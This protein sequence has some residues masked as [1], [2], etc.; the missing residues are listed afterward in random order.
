MVSGRDRTRRTVL[1]LFGITAGAG[2]LGTGY[3]AAGGNTDVNGS[4]TADNATQIGKKKDTQENKP[5]GRKAHDTGWPQFQYD[6]ANLG[7]NPGAT[8]PKSN[9]GTQWEFSGDFDDSRFGVAVVDQTV[10]VT[11]SKAV[12]ALSAESGTERWRYHNPNANRQDYASQS[13]TPTPA[14]VDG[15]LYTAF[16]EQVQSNCERTSSG[17]LALN[18]ETGKP[19]W[20]FKSDVVEEFGVPVVADEMVFV[21]SSSQ[22]GGKLY[23]LDAISGE[24]VWETPA[25]SGGITGLSPPSVAVVD[26]IVYNPDTR[27]DC[28][29]RLTTFEAQTGKELWTADLGFVFN[30][31]DNAPAVAD[32]SIYIGTAEINGPHP[33]FYALS[34]DDAS[35]RWEYQVPGKY[36]NGVFSSPVIAD[37]TAYVSFSSWNSVAS[38]GVYAFSTDDGSIKW[39]TSTDNL[40]SNVSTLTAPMLADGVL[41]VNQYVLNAADGTVVASIGSNNRGH[42]IGAAVAGTTY[43]TSGRDSLVAYTGDTEQPTNDQVGTNDGT[44][45]QG[46]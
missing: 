28:G 2:A 35:V 12:Y 4:Q 20:R 29:T 10:Y 9:F 31:V 16:Y 44:N 41:Y 39:H 19:L 17:L 15:V 18:A 33:T 38:T 5:K 7:V 32:N 21:A 42:F 46:N 1:K 6:A 26:G 43:Y 40:L 22:I 24:K 23:V 36:S 13:L 14:V 45:T 3:V 25:T 8:G 11:S 30:A 27:T 37:G 34:R